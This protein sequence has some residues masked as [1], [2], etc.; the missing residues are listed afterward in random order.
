MAAI[1][2]QAVPLLFD[3]NIERKLNGFDEWICNPTIGTSLAISGPLTD[4]QRERLKSFLATFVQGGQ[5]ACSDRACSSE[6]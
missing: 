4:P 5:H 2:L 1:F 3:C 6:G